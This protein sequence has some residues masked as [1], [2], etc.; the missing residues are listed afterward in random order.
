[1]VSMATYPSQFSNIN[2]TYSSPTSFTLEQQ[3][4]ATI[5]SNKENVVVFR[6]PLAGEK[7][8]GSG[9][10][11]ARKPVLHGLKTP[12]TTARVPFGGKSTN[13]AGHQTG[14][15]PLQSVKKSSATTKRSIESPSL[16][17]KLSQFTVSSDFVSK[18]PE[19]EYPEIEYTPSPEKETFQYDD[20]DLDIDFDLI[21]K[22]IAI[23]V[24]LQPTGDLDRPIDVH[25]HRDSETKRISD[26]TRKQTASKPIFGNQTPRSPG[27]SFNSRR[28]N[29]MA[30]TSSTLSKRTSKPPKPHSNNLFPGAPN[31]S[32]DDS[33]RITDEEILSGLDENL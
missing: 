28:P 27:R 15:K 31:S 4:M 11:T 17:T 29:F 20:L 3:N 1:M 2:I 6:T 13:I 16:N 26:R 5:R 10:V 23:P 7:G 8:N 19:S 25:V 14:K 24:Y 18:S 21:A 32:D 12:A 22:S 9:N 30:P 33:V